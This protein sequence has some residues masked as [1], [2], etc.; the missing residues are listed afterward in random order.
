MGAYRVIDLSGGS[1]PRVCETLLAVDDEAKLVRYHYDSEAS[2][3]EV[4]PAAVTDY[5]E[6]CQIAPVRVPPPWPDTAGAGVPHPAARRPQITST[7]QTYITWRTNF[8][9][10]S[11]EDMGAMHAAL[12]GLYAK[13][14]GDIE[15]AAKKE[16]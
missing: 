3:K 2:S 1:G 7:N 12:Q 16:E 4:F 6:T 9:V 11:V 15:A 13:L 10:A 5:I 8:K 14:S